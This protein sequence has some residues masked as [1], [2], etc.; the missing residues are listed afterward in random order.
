MRS[1]PLLLV[2][3][4]AAH[5]DSGLGRHVRLFV[6][7]LASLKDEADIRVVLPR[8][9]AAPEGMRTLSVPIRP[10]RLF[11][12]ALWPAW[13][14]ALRPRAVF[15]L[16]Q[17]LPYLRPRSRYALLVPDAAPLENLPFPASGHPAFNRAWMRKR[18]PAAN[19]IVTSAEFTRQRLHA[20]LGIPLERISVVPPVRGSAP[21]P[22]PSREAPPSAPYFLAMGNV[23]PRKNYPGLLR[24]YALAAERRPDLPPLHILGHAAWDGGEA[25]ALSEKSGLENR[26]FFH[27][28]VSESQREAF[29]TGCAA[30]LSASLYEGF[31]LPLFEALQAGKPCVYHGGG[32][33]DE[34]AREF[35]LPADCADPVSL[36]EALEKIWVEPELRR[37]L[38]SRVAAGFRAR[39]SDYD[40]GDALRCALLP[41]LAG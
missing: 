4:L 28:H 7:G 31:G 40:P 38:E 21:V 41:L 24:A 30:F 6:E 32:A 13:I 15:C 14:A 12:E 39:W 18:I 26:V 37:N 5:N 34:F 17:T 11:C 16:G 2:E 8:G 10:Y 23:E 29:L 36:A 27:G 35:A 33:Q 9:F 3:A 1:K 25:R 19:R 20:L 22:G